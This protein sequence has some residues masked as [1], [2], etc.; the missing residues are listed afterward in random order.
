[1]RPLTALWALIPLVAVN[2]EDEDAV[3][4]A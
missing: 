2:A 3:L 4:M 1:M